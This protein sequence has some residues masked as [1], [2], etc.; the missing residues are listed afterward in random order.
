MKQ[1]VQ[2]KVMRAVV[3]KEG[4][5]RSK[6]EESFAS[7]GG[8]CWFR[9]DSKS[10]EILLEFV[11]GKTMGKIV[12]RGWDCPL[13]LDLGKRV[14]LGFWRAWKTVLYGR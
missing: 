9:V 8:R 3:K 14:L 6:G 7:L 4:D 2:A 12:E 13:G 11:N 5:G 1:V 10:F